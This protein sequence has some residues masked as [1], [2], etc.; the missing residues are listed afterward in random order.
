MFGARRAA[1]DLGHD[2][3]A[4]L[5]LRGRIAVMFGGA[6]SRF[7]NDRRA[8]Y[9]SSRE[10]LR[11]IVERGAIGVVDVSTAEDEVRSPWARGAENWNRPS[12]RLRGGDGVAIDTW[13][14]LRAAASV[15]AAAAD[16]LFAGAQSAAVLFDAAREGTLKGSSAGPAAPGSRTTIERVESRNVVSRAGR[17]DPAW[18]ASTWGTPRNG[19]V[20]IGATVEAN[21]LQRRLDKRWGGTCRG[22]SRVKGAAGRSAR[23]GSSR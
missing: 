10:K 4:G 2:D 14:Q 11:N 16:A 12:M 23:G 3:F 18:Q 13:P 9:A 7:D 8:F 21:A 17:Q 5:D 20:G 15:S 19:R 6:P 22:G 1:P